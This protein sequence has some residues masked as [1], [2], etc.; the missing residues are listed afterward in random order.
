MHKVVNQRSEVGDSA[1]HSVDRLERLV[2]IGENPFDVLIHASRTFAG[3][4]Q[5]PPKDFAAYGIVAFPSRAAGKDDV[6]RHK[7]IC[8][9]YVA[10]LPDVTEVQTQAHAP[11]K[12]QMVTVWP[13]ESNNE[14]DRISAMPRDRACPD[15]VS[16]YGLIKSKEAIAAAL[17]AS[18]A[19]FDGGGPFLLAWSPAEK[20]GDRDALVLV[21]NLSDVTTT[22]QAR[23]IFDRWSTDIQENPELWVKGW[24]SEKIKMVIRL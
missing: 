4:G 8:S 16:H 20:E 6:Q 3:P 18:N 10:G 22:E 19:A 7:M 9:S 5:Y 14:A 17:R 23:E 11:I 2:G 12:T 15:A 13:I 24:N 21:S 1:K